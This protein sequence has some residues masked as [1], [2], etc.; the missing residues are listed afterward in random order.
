MIGKFTGKY[1]FESVTNTLNSWYVS[2]TSDSGSTILKMSASQIT[3]REKFAVYNTGDYSKSVICLFNRQF[4]TVGNGSGWLMA[5]SLQEDATPL[6]FSYSDY[7][8]MT[9]NRYDNGAGKF[10]MMRYTVNN[11]TPFLLFPDLTSQ[12]NQ[13]VGVEEVY[14]ILNRILITPGIDEIRSMGGLQN[15]DFKRVDL[16]GAD[17]SGLDLTGADFEEAD[18]T[19]VNFSNA[20]LKNA[21]FKNAVMNGTSFSG[22][23]VSEADFTGGDLTH[24][25]WGKGITAKKACFKDSNAFKASMEG[26]VLDQADFTSA[27]FGSTNLK[28]AK[29]GKAVLQNANFSGTV[30][31]AA[32]LT[33]IIAGKTPDLPGVNLSFAY[34]PDAKLTDAHLNGANLSHVQMYG[35]DARADNA[36][37]EEADL[38]SSNLTGMDLSQA[39]LQGAILDECI[40]VNCILVGAQLIPSGDGQGVSFAKA[41]LQG[42]N[43]KDAVFEKVNMSN[44][45]VAFNDGVPLFAILSPGYIEDLNKGVFPQGLYDDFKAHGYILSENAT[46]TVIKKNTKWSVSQDVPLEELGLGYSEFLLQYSNGNIKVSGTAIVINRLNDK[47]EL[48]KNLQKVVPTNI[49]VGLLDDDSVCPNQA[50]YKTNIRNKVSWEDMMTAVV[51][52]HPPKCIPDPYHWCPNTCMLED[53]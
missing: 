35:S 16:A 45:A 15:G 37:L 7:N 49:T 50:A 34:M 33:G 13:N 1:A 10:V 27:D 19:G 51:P 21:N 12:I 40:L 46:V 4:I 23:D 48:E 30:L 52:P 2:Y 43:F 29:L 18:L 17:L 28:G 44:S 5:S 47:N 20:T 3:D 53:I 22:A 36:V 26:A 42:A 32:D 24:I 8:L 38:S 11:P 14:F 39:H 6:Y 9:L 31:E 25:I 41:N